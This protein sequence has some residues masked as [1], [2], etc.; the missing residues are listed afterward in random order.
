VL[1]DLNDFYFSLPIKVLRGNIMQNLIESLPIEERYTYIY[2]GNSQTL[3]HILITQ[4]LIDSFLSL[5]VMHINSEFDYASHLSDHD[6]L[7]ATFKLE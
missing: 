3:D 6:P 5:D 1:G 2:E 4:G 7:V